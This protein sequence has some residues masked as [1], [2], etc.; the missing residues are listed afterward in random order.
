MRRGLQ[1]ADANEMA[2]THPQ[3]TMYLIEFGIK[4][5]NGNVTQ[6]NAPRARHG[7]DA[8]HGLTMF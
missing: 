5:P 8:Y 3:A 7:C 2:A 6:N 1:A 4:L